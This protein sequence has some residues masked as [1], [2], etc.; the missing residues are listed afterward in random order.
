V[1]KVIGTLTAARAYGAPE[2]PGS[3]SW[4]LFH[5]SNSLCKRETILKWFFKKI[6]YFFMAFQHSVSWAREMT[7]SLKARLTT[8][9]IRQNFSV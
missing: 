8:K 7:Q 3:P 1:P 6:I 2:R 4:T 9:N 5:S